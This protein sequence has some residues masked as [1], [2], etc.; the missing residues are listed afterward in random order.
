MGTLSNV[1]SSLER[2]DDEI[3]KIRAESM[4]LRNARHCMR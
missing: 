3:S 2:L 4:K 1:D